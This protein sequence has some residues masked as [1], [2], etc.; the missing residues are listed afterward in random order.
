VA[1]TSQYNTKQGSAILSFLAANPDK[2][3]TVG[4]IAAQ[5]NESGAH[6]GIA[7]IY[8]HL[9]K[10]EQSGLVCKFVVDSI[11]GAS[12]RYVGDAKADGLHLMCED[13]GQMLAVNCTS[14]NE[15]ENHLLQ[16]HKFRVDHAKTVVYGKCAICSANK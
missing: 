15:F 7:T 3:I 16:N 14:V 9:N 5:L 11:I 1:R 8:R 4:A 6:I 10:L 12:Y 13:C 2:H